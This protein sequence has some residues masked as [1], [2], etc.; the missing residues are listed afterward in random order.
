MDREIW[1]GVAMIFGAAA[2]CVAV[3]ALLAWIFGGPTNLCIVGF[4]SRG[5]LV[6]AAC[7]KTEETP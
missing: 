6:Y 3:V 4:T 1:I 5:D 7:P 2:A